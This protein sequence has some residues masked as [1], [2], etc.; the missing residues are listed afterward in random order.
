MAGRDPGP[1]VIGGHRLVRTGV[2]V[3]AVTAAV[4][5]VWTGAAAATT[6]P[7]TVAVLG[8]S[9]SSGEGLPGAQGACGRAPDAWGAQV[10]DA[11]AAADVVNLACTGAEV[12]DVVVG[13]GADGQPAT[14]QLDALDGQRDLVLLT[15]GGNDIGFSALVADCL[16]V[17]AQVDRSDVEAE[18][19]TRWRDSVATG[20][21]MFGCDTP[22]SAVAA[23]V[24][25]LGAGDRFTLPDGGQGRLADV[26]VAVAD[27]AVADGGTLVVASY[28]ALFHP[29]DEWAERYGRRCHGVLA[30][31]ADSFVE[32]TT[33][34][35]DRV[36]EE[37]ALAAT[38]V[39]DRVRVLH[40][41]V[42]AAAS[43]ELPVDGD[44][45]PHGLCG[46]GTAWVN[47]LALVE[48]G[49]DPSAATAAL[50]GGQLDLA[51]IGARPSASF[52]PGT[53]GHRGIAQVVLD[54]L[55][56]EESP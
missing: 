54:R 8:D 37:A 21:A 1:V 45:A 52:H 20:R 43:G 24:D 18:Q 31:D 3:L 40:A 51:A 34:L 15:I 9:Y 55:A 50:L 42:R 2:A 11:L 49:I 53:A 23:T 13:G 48:G 7:T 32:V 4:G 5:A 47:G 56:A 17:D 39:G 12:V 22:P 38:A 28:P 26:Y 10:A 35:A 44:A 33:R 30:A 16:D 36:A 29:P 25:Q 6:G 27:R 46:P 41:D 14:A 19:S